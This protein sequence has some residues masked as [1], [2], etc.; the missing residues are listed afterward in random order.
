MLKRLPMLFI[1]LAVSTAVAAGA[2]VWALTRQNPTPVQ[3]VIIKAE[4]PHDPRAFTQGLVIDDGVMHESTGLYGESSL[5]RVDLSSGKVEVLVPLDQR[6]FG[7]GMTIL[8]DEIFVVTWQS[9]IGYVYDRATLKF[10]RTFRYG[11]E[12][13]GLTDNGQHLI[14]SDG[15]DILRY[16]DPQDGRVVRRLAVRDQGHPVREINELERVGDEL[17]ANIWHSER[18]ARISLETGEVTAWI[19]ASPLFKQ[20]HLANTAD[21]VLNGI[22]YDRKTRK[23][24][25]TGKRWSKLFEVELQPTKF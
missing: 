7:E 11:G 3:Q 19:D 12:G 9:R 22:A 18:I 13:W 6:L 14:L 21:D 20:V 17:F 8:N 2:G 15:T 4:H 1:P 25:L 23:L 10:R 24:Y 16:L 5:R